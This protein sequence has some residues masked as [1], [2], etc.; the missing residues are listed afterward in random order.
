MW[1][2][3]NRITGRWGW[4]FFGDCEGPG[5]CMHGRTGISRNDP[6]GAWG[7]LCTCEYNC[8]NAMEFDHEY[9]CAAENWEWTV[10]KDPVG[11]CYGGIS[12]GR[13]ATPSLQ[14]EL[15]C[16]A[17]GQ[18]TGIGEG[19]I[20]LAC[21]DVVDPLMGKQCFNCGRACCDPM[22][23]YHPTCKDPPAPEGAKHVEGTCCCSCEGNNGCCCLRF[24][25]AGQR[26]CPDDDNV[27][28]GL[29]LDIFCL[30]EEEY[31]WPPG[32]GE[33]TRQ[34]YASS[35]CCCEE[36]EPDPIGACCN[37]KTDVCLQTTSLEC[38]GPE[39]D[40]IWYGPGC[41]CDQAPPWQDCLV[42]PCCG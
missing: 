7:T 4:T 40:E 26:F 21:M 19:G 24:D 31:E 3:I 2:E 22:A 36:V 33:E 32:S 10:N 42:C 17:C 1:D 9:S 23:N 6:L 41:V 18:E 37:T 20:S 34:G 30:V 29:A 28:C 14:I 16:S 12:Q 39:T 13:P 27:T 5:G 38:G 11:P 25:E 35:P 15:P 8:F